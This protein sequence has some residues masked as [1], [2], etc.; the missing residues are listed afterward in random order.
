MT[1]GRRIAWLGILLLGLAHGRPGRTEPVP[2]PAAPPAATPET[3]IDRQPAAAEPTTALPSARSK[4][5]SAQPPPTRSLDPGF[6]PTLAALV[7][8]LFYHGVGH[9]LAGDRE[10]ARDL[11]IVEGI[12]GGTM[13]L[14]GGALVANGA[15]GELS[16]PL[17]P[18]LLAAT[19][20]FL[21]SWL[22]D[23]H[24]SAGG[25]RLR[26]SPIRAP[27]RLQARLAYLHVVDPQ[28]AYRDFVDLALDVWHDAWY[29]GVEGQFA[30]DDDNLRLQLTAGYRLLGGRPG[31]P[32]RDGSRLQLH[33][34]LGHHGFGPE[35]FT[36]R[37]VEAW[38][39]GRYDLER[40]SPT[41]G[42]SFAEMDVG[43]ILEAIAYHQPDAVDLDIDAQLISRFAFGWYLPWRPGQLRVFYDHR[44]D[45]FAGG[46]AVSGGGNGFTGSFGIDGRMYLNDRLGV[47]ALTQAGSAY[48]FQLGLLVRM[49]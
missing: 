12:S 45:R 28:F 40:I 13:L 7:P 19:G 29:A 6:L 11:L 30:T 38:V 49:P 1:C 5:D 46:L 22:A 10:T 41:L 32:G 47:T 24:G 37:T 31:A 3:T 20:V 25:A 34:A 35:L 14:A 8:G 27:D 16:R 36:R 48:L 42:S 21:Q 39:H 2:T 9:R 23:I 43:L 17:I 18:V 4:P 44:R 15:S 33:L 26:G